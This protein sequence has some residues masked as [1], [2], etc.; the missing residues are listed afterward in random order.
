LSL[1]YHPD[2][3]KSKGAQDK[4]AEINNAYD[5]LS[6]EEKRKNY[7][8]YGDE[9]GSPQFGTGTPGGHGGYHFTSGG[10]GN[11]HF[12]FDPNEWQTAGRQGNSESFS[13]S[14]GNPSSSGSS[15]D[16]GLNDIFSNIF[17]GGMGGGSSFGGFGGPSRTQSR[18]SPSSSLKTVS[19]HVFKK[20]IVDQGI[21]WLLLSYVPSSKG[22]HAL[23]S[24]VEE[25]AGQLQGALKAGSI[26]CQKD[27]S[28]CKENGLYPSKSAQ[29]FVYSYK[30]SDKG[31][32][33]EYNGNWDARSLKS[34]CQDQLP[35][36]SRR[37]D[38]GRYDFTSSSEEKLP[39]VLLLSTKK[40]T[41][42]IWRTLS[43]LYRRRVI[44]YDAEVRDISD[45][46]LKKLGVDALPAVVGWLPNGEKHILKTG[47]AVKDLKSGIG[48]LS[49]VLEWFEKK[50]KKTTSSQPKRSEK[51]ESHEELIPLLTGSNV[52]TVCGENTPVCIIGAFRSPKGREKLET[53]LNTVS[54]KSLT[55]RQNHFSSSGD[56]TSFSL[57][58]ANKQQEFLNS[59]DR[60]GFKSKD[61]LVVAY[62]PRKGKFAVFTN[63]LMSNEVE[64]FIGGVMNGDFTTIQVSAGSFLWMQMLPPW[65]ATWSYLCISARS[66]DLFQQSLIPDVEEM[67]PGSPSH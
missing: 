60:S 37:V 15:F 53:I 3:N 1:K 25:V 54:K 5:V 9:K 42:V 32:L 57:L 21:T 29:I 23:E 63:D 20:E 47:I 7:D 52:N 17:G 10:P 13:F 58:D 51:T 64:L 59:L 4:F 66:C 8:L 41:P 16:F 44:F 19:S 67:A 62:K 39:R 30:A 65:T 27:P 24:I 46:V 43:G 49:G 14:F 45:P 18:S 38:V 33:A 48:E 55:R 50:N 35:R 28:F 6:D 40:D 34:F 11:S 2:K 22:F 56:S 12:T 31:S 26:N 36:F 61:H